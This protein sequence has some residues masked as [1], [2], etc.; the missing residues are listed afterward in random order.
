MN[1]QKGIETID[2]YLE[3]I[4]VKKDIDSLRGV[5]IGFLQLMRSFFP[6]ADQRIT[7]YDAYL[8]K[9]LQKD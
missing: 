9:A 2:H 5:N 1:L 6:D 7:E 4:K 8:K 3:I